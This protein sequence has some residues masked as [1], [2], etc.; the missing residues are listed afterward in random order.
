MTK[1]P[2]AFRTIS[3]V[4]AW[5]DTPA[6]VL[7]FWE[8]RFDD[9]KPV[10]RAGGRRYYRPEDMQLLGGIKHL[11]HT[12]GHTIKSVQDRI[13]SDGPSAVAAFSPPLTAPP[14]GAEAQVQEARAPMEVETLAAGP[15]PLRREPPAQVPAA[16]SV[17]GGGATPS[18]ASAR[19]AAAP[20]PSPAAADPEPATSPDPAPQPEALSS[21]SP[22]DDAPPIGFFFDDSDDA[23]PAEAQSGT[24]S[25]LSEPEPAIAPIATSGPQHAPSEAAQASRAPAAPTD[26]DDDTPG[27]APPLPIAARLRAILPEDLSAAQRARLATL[28]GRLGSMARGQL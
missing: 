12:E 8:S 11:L 13:K 9:L 6:H 2:D 25:P 4:A 20:M 26:P 17:D 18:F 23:A 28:A 14:A 22:D 10:K 24:F 19:T 7:R 15:A 27:L 3:E 21:E 5:L 16:A 1:S